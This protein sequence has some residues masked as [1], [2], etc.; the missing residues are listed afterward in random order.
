[1]VTF[2]GGLLIPLHCQLHIAYIRPAFFVS[3]TDAVM[4]IRVNG[5]LVGL[6]GTFQIEFDVSATFS[7]QV[8][9]VGWRIELVPI[10]VSFLQ[11]IDGRLTVNGYSDAF[12]MDGTDVVQDNPVQGLSFLI[13]RSEGE[14]VFHVFL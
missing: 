3:L 14:Q 11:P 12:L 1:M 7:I 13:F 6:E 5:K 4:G 8:S 2:L 9:Q 10:L